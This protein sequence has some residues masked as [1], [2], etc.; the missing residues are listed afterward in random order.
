MCIRDRS[1]PV[2][3]K[4][5]DDSY[6]MFKM[7]Q[8][9]L[10]MKFSEQKSDSDAKFNIQNNKFD[11]LKNEIQ[12]IN[13]RKNTNEIIR[14][15]LNKLEHSVERMGVV[16]MNPNKNNTN[17]NYNDKELT[18]DNDNVENNECNICLLYTSR[19]V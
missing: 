18:N 6:E 10:D 13:R 7:I 1:T 2:Q 14:T 11:E 4:K 9:M 12:E 17:E 19:C 15:S 3:G 16:V 8:T 5:S